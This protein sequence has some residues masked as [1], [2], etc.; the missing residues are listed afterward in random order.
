[1]EF[2]NSNNGNEGPIVVVAGIV[3]ASLAGVAFMIFMI[4]NCVFYF[5]FCNTTSRGAPIT[6]VVVVVVGSD[7]G[8]RNDS[9]SYDGDGQAK[10]CPVMS[11]SPPPQPNDI[12]AP[13]L[14]QL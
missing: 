7:D 9:Y 12:E 6:P 1:M 5:E 2:D 11:S 13:Q 14:S 3:L 8:E 4:M 10:K